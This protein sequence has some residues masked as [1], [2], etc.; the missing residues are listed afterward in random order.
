LSNINF[1]IVATPIGDYKDISL[2]ALEILKNVDFI[3]CEEEREYKKLFGMI[4]IQPKNFILCNEHTETESI[5]LTLELLK[6]GEKG[7]LIS[8]CGTP[9]FED[10]GFNL[11]QFIRK[12]KYKITSIPGANSMV[13][14]MTLSPFKIKDFYFAGFLPKKQ[15]ERE[16]KIL[17]ILKREEVI[18]F[19]EAPYRLKNVI[20]SLKKC[21]KNRK[22]CVTYNLTLED[23]NVFSGMPSEVEQKMQKNNIEKGEY[24]I[25]IEKKNG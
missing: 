22:I 21:V 13:T 9:L 7:A 1:Y 19:M 6:K 14:A 18:I 2:R 25:I 24:L 12:N 8:D 23:E 15:D 5:E 20:D 16:K 17:N 11:I 4:G 10:P 3:V